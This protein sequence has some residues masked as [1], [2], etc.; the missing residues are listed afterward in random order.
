MLLFAQL[1]SLY[2]IKCKHID[3]RDKLSTI[4]NAAIIHIEK[5]VKN[6][7]RI[8]SLKKVVLCANLS[9]NIETENNYTN[10]KEIIRCKQFI[11]VEV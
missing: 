1:L 4:D 2:T 6:D 10:V 5:V 7:T 8:C 3:R 9:S 11:I